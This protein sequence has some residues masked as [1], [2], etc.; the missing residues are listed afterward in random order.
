MSAD[1]SQPLTLMMGSRESDCMMKWYS[2]LGAP[3]M[4]RTR[5]SRSTTLTLNSLRLFSWDSSSGNS[6]SSRRNLRSPLALGMAVTTRWF[7]PQAS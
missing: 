7:R 2:M 1:C 3:A 6:G 4:K 5:S